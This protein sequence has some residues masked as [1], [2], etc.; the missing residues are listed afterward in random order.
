MRLLIIED[1][2]VFAK[3]LREY[4]HKSDIMC[5]L[6]TTAEHGL[7]MLQTFEYNLVITDMQ[8]DGFYNG[9]QLIERIRGNLINNSQ[10]SLIP[11]IMMSAYGEMNDK[12]SSLH[13]GADDYLFKPFNCQ[14][15][16]AR[17]YSLVRRSK[18]YAKNIIKFK[19]VTVDI[20]SRSVKVNGHE[21]QL[22]CKEYKFLQFLVMN[23]GKN[24]T[25]DAILSF[26]YRGTKMAGAKICDVLACK[27]RSK[28][29]EFSKEKHIV[30][31]WGGGYIIPTDEENS[32]EYVETTQSP[33]IK[34]NYDEIQE[35][36]QAE[37]NKKIS[38]I[39]S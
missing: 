2:V 9:L 22:T 31:L 33:L 12:L 16:I 38:Q 6:A 3:R 28:L 5:D 14:E 10:K 18:G 34:E 39:S 21:V 24:I 20:G 26:L 15:L 4:L 11:I 23:K 30:T 19:D 32:Q 27:I 25:K 36:P 8:L 7:K 35:S 13:L 1:D 17:I 29:A 37:D